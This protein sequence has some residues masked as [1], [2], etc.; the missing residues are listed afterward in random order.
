MLQDKLL[1]I[2]IKQYLIIRNCISKKRF[3]TKHKL[4]ES[5]IHKIKNLI[6]MI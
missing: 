4:T 3:K 2:N 5:S 6:D 1:L